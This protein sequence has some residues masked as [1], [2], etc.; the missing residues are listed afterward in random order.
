MFRRFVNL[1]PP[2]VPPQSGQSITYFDRALSM[3]QAHPSELALLLENAWNNR[4]N[5]A[6]E[7]LGHPDRRSDL[8]GIGRVGPLP[9][10][11]GAPFSTLIGRVGTGRGIRW[12][13][14]IYAYMIENTRIYEIFRKVV[15][16]YLHGEQLGAPLP[17]S[18]HWLRNTEE[19]FYKDPA[20]FLIT[21]IASH[22][23][24]DLRATRRNAY[25]RM[26]NMDL[27]HG[28]DDK[29]EYP[30]VKAKASNSDFVNAFEDFLRE[31]WVG[32]SNLTT[33]SGANPTDDAAIANLAERLHNMLRTRRE[34]GNLSREEFYAV[35]T[36]EWFHLTLEFDTP[37]VRA[38][39][40]EG[41]SPKER[42]F[43]IADRVKLPAHGKSWSFFEIAELISVLLTL[44]E[45]GALN[46]TTS[47][48]ALYDNINFPGN[49]LPD[50]LRAIITYWSDLTGHDVKT[51]KTQ[52]TA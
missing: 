41:M 10:P 49:T 45:T 11:G 36:M 50:D 14:L 5:I 24:P 42:L 33:T 20:P 47:A 4:A 25:D 37:I 1:F 8:A 7:K 40:A 27:N 18:E 48:R 17:G 23:R 31:V 29:S 43:N 16:E 2:L 30:Y 39:R 51:R 34:T 6:T 46:T 44:I 19:L 28:T 22:I 15:Y 3:F 9:L 21:S 26:F 35:S 12:H 32:I 13:H 38:L 52:V